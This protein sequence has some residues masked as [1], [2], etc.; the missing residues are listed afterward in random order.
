MLG[1]IIA[2]IKVEDFF[3]Y[4]WEKEPLAVNRR[5]PEFFSHLLTLDAIDQM[6]T[7][8][9]IRFPDIRI[10]SA[11]R[12]ISRSEYAAEGGRLKP[13]SVMK[14]FQEGGTIILNHQHK[15]QPEIARFCRS[16]EQYFSHPF[17]TNIYL[18]PPNAQGFGIHFD[19]HDVFILQISGRKDWRIF[20]RAIEL[21][22][23]GQGFDPKDEDV[24]SVQMECSLEA[25]DLLYIPRGILHKASSLDEV[26]L[27]ATVGVL[28]KTW[29]DLILEAVSQVIINDTTFRESMPAGFARP[30][31]DRSEAKKI[32]HKRMRDLT[33]KVNFENV[34]EE[35]IK[36]FV[37]TRPPL[38]QG[39]MKQLSQISGLVEESMVRLREGVVFR[40]ERGSDAISLSFYGKTI[41][42]PIACEGPLLHLVSSKEILLNTL[43]A[44]KDKSDIDDILILIRRLITEGFIEVVD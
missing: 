20:D 41:D 16:M 42:F 11:T 13:D 2:P 5:S 12:E 44:D 3:R 40:L 35:F 23:A 43:S 28:A 34:F 21:P 10:I 9:D 6:I 7:T 24:G 17:Q 30:E 26:S 14:L 25:G 15:W 8:S 39:Q 22:L 4:N 36:D 19:T 1:K 29:A 32:F 38:L 33:R 27:H 18:T 37:D 31:F